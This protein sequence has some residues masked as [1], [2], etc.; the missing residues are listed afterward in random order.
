MDELGT[1]KPCFCL[2]YKK[3]NLVQVCS[4]TL[5]IL[6]FW[7]E[8]IFGLSPC[9]ACMGMSGMLNQFYDKFNVFFIFRQ[10][11]C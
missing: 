2:L 11:S 3:K 9:T 4:M 7:Y 8:S 5:V 6:R 1:L 10:P